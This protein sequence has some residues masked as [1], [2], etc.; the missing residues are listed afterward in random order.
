MD[1]IY[2]KNTYAHFIALTNQIFR[3]Q[4]ILALAVMVEI[5][6]TGY[7]LFTK[8]L[9]KAIVYFPIRLLMKSVVI[10]PIAAFIFAFFFS[11]EITILH[12]TNKR[13]STHTE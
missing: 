8:N 11:L 12:Y 2:V 1:P 6:L 3:A 7:A 5:N 4:A 13:N 9:M 10:S